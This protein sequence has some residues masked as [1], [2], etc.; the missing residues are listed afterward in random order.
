MLKYDN[1]YG[2]YWN[3]WTLQELFKIF[4]LFM[5]WN[6]L[7]LF[8]SAVIFPEDVLIRHI[9]TNMF[10]LYLL[11]IW[12]WRQDVRNCKKV[13]IGIQLRKTGCEWHDVVYFIKS[14]TCRSSFGCSQAAE[15]TDVVSCLS[16]WR[17]IIRWQ[18]HSVRLAVAFLK[19][20]THFSMINWHDERPVWWIM[21]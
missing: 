11:K 1:K 9:H 13:Y 7:V 20:L 16:R 6:T 14:L 5:V 12:Q 10:L 19:L 3:R 2:L 18:W 4:L 17:V 15:A 8:S 21:R